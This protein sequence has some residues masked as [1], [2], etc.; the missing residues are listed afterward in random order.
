[1]VK[2]FGPKEPCRSGML[3][4]ASVVSELLVILR[5]A[6]SIERKAWSLRLAKAL[7]MRSFLLVSGLSHEHSKESSGQKGK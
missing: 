7:L 6:V 1:M 5:P 2:F 4:V 3:L